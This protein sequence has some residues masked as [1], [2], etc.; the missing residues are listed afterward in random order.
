MQTNTAIPK[1]SELAKKAAD[2]LK[3]GHEY[4]EEYKKTYTACAVV[5]LEAD[6][7]HFILFTR[8]EYKGDILRNVPLVAFDKPLT[9]PFET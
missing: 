6:N 3:A 5:W 8:S 1:D 2:L 7:G 4:W 9:K